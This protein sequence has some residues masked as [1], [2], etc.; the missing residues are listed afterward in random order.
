MLGCHTT[1]VIPSNFSIQTV[2]WFR[3]TDTLVETFVFSPFNNKVKFWINLKL[4]MRFFPLFRCHIKFPIILAGS[5]KQPQDTDLLDSLYWWYPCC[6]HQLAKVIIFS[7]THNRNSAIRLF[8]YFVSLLFSH[9][10]L[11]GEKKL[12]FLSREAN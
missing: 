2:S 8:I 12:R 4:L 11:T 9:F 3:L 1:I 5:D 10:I 6:C 7:L